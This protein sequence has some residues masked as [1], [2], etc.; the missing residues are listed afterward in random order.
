M[1]KRCCRQAGVVDASHMFDHT[2]R[3]VWIATYLK[4]NDKNLIMR[5]R[6]LVIQILKIPCFMISDQTRFDW[7]RWRRLEYSS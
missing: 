6:L 5:S 4:N 1:I 2:F 3:S 7:M